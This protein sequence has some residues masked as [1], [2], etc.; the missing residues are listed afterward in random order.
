MKNVTGEINSKIHR[1]GINLTSIQNIAKMPI[2]TRRFN[3]TDNKTWE[4]SY[5]E[6]DSHKVKLGK[7]SFIADKCFEEIQEKENESSYSYHWNLMSKIN[8]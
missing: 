8:F 7:V 4:R 3:Y 2:I 5:D 1:V 6:K